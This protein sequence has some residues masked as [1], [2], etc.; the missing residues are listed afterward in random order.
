VD[1]YGR[2]IAKN[3]ADYLAKYYKLSEKEIKDKRFKRL[4]DL[5]EYGENLDGDV[6]EKEE[7]GSEEEEVGEP[8]D[9]NEEASSEYQEYSS[10][11]GE[12][13]E[14][15]MKRYLENADHDEEAVMKDDQEAVT[16]RL[17]IQNMDW[18]GFS[19]V[20]LLAVLHHFAPPGGIVKKVTI[21]PSDLGKAA[22]AREAL[23]GPEGVWK[24][25]RE[26][27]VKK[28]YQGF[29]EHN[30]RRYESLQRRFNVRN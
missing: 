16:S 12:D 10:D 18:S 1:E 8:E 5:R 7:Q 15:A 27:D 13:I 19:S 29:D 6:E 4:D 22:M 14:N 23:S 20:D 24:D 28:A 21:Y 25:T 2:P 3:S 26:L 17:A 30:L 9:E 11:D